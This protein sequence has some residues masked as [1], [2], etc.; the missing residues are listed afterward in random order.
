MNKMQ[1]S[2]EEF[3]DKVR[4][5]LAE[6]TGL[7][8]IAKAAPIRDMIKILKRDPKNVQSALS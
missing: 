8:N 3:K 1:W 4:E 2:Y 5:T 7:E 6:V